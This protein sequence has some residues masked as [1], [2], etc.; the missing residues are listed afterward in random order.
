M[1]RKNTVEITLTL[2]QVGVD[3]FKKTPVYNNMLYP[4]QIAT[5]HVG[6]NVMVVNHTTLGRLRRAATWDH[7]NIHLT[8]KPQ[9]NGSTI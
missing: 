6:K 3:R 4:S 1:N 2:T 8:F 9:N 7:T 5:L